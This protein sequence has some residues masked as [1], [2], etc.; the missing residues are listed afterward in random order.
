MRALENELTRTFPAIKKQIDSLL[1]A[2]LINIDKSS[3]KRSIRIKDDF[4]NHIKNIFLYSLQTDLTDLFDE[5]KTIIE[6]YYLGNKFGKNLD[7][8][9]IIL[10]KDCNTKQ[11]DEIKEIINKIFSNY[12]IDIV[13]VVFMSASEREKRY[14]LAD[15]FVLNIMRSLQN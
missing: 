1:E 7:M 4:H 2:R 14:R 11:I 5:H 15:R 6:K 3:M 10:Y 8:D 12:F 9:L 13:S